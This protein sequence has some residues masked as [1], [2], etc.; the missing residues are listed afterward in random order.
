M[1]KILLINPPYADYIYGFKQARH[2]H[3]SLGL[4]YL[5]SYIKQHHYV[6]EVLDA[7][8]LMLSTDQTV[9]RVIAS[10]ADVI[11]ITCLTLLMPKVFDICNKIKENSKVPRT[12]IVGGPHV[13]FKDKETLSECAAID[14]VAR[15]EGE[16]TLKELMA[17]RPIRDIAG[18]SYR[19]SSGNIISNKDRDLIRNLDDLSFP[20]RELF[21]LEKYNLGPIFNR[22]IH[23]KQ[24]ASMIT[25]RGCVAKCS[26]C[27]SSSFWK[28]YRMRS[29]S[30]VINEIEHLIREYGVK[31][32]IFVDDSLT[33]SKK[34]I[35]EFCE[36]LKEKRIKIIWV[37]YS[38][39]DTLTDEIIKKMKEA[40]CYGV[41]LGIESGS[42]RILDTVN[43][44]LKLSTIENTMKALRK[45]NIKILC[46][47]MIGLPGDDFQSTYE[48]IEF[49]KKIKPDLVEFNVTT[50]FPGTKLYEDSLNKGFIS[51]GYI[52]GNMS[53]HKGTNYHNENL[54]SDD[55]QR[56]YNKA[57]REFYLRP[58][59]VWQVIR[60]C[61][62]YPFEIKNYYAF[63]MEFMRE[64]YSKI[65]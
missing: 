49:S 61:L 47:F 29:V 63:F 1:K 60:R 44:R 39:A 32:I 5:A 2:F 6:A 15:G 18:I 45:A 43:K 35:T 52:W 56:L 14:I 21:P 33:A 37:C 26:F 10:D 58:Y 62:R 17:N 4:A 25:S 27:S 55:I 16:E 34:R 23:G 20:A 7:N 50:P 57:I 65:K 24:L 48:T 64:S 28:R 22:G 13:T 42:Q 11:G 53:L 41:Q 59:F 54:R 40:G 51:E 3:I 8:A 38:R 19:D 30:N 12:I 9:D 46:F 36:L 31:Q